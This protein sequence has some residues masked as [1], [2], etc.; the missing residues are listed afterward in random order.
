MKALRIFS[1]IALLLQQ[2]FVKLVW[3][4]SFRGNLRQHTAFGD[5][6][7]SKNWGRR[8]VDLAENNDLLKLPGTVRDGVRG[9]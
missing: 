9:M 1:G 4:Q 7:G 3:I 5:T 2:K 6:I 8:Q